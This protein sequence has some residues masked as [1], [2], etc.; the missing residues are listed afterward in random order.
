MKQR[1][2]NILPMI[3]FIMIIVLVLGGFAVYG[4]KN[5][6]SWDS[7]FSGINKNNSHV[8]DDAGELPTNHVGKIIIQ[9]SSPDVYISNHDSE[10]VKANFYGE[11]IG[12]DESERPK[13][14]LYRQG[15]TITVRIVYPAIAGLTYKNA[16]LDVVIPEKWEGDLEINSVSGDIFA[17]EL[18]G[19]DISIN[20][21]SGRIKADV[22]K[23][24]G[25]F[26]NTSVSGDCSIETV[27]CKEGRFNSS[28]GDITIQS[29]KAE[30]MT[31]KTVSGRTKISMT[32]GKAEFESSS[33]KMDIE[34][35]N[36]FD[37]LMAKS[38]SGAIELGIPEDSTFDIN[39][40]TVSGDIDCRD[41]PLKI[42]TS[43]EN[44]LNG[45][46]GDGGSSIDVTTSSGSVKVYSR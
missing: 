6:D 40:K 21:S 27:G 5:K 9:S 36:G 28:S 17:K 3:G 29:A 45:T 37:R 13:L 7:I 11:I 44:E 14:E 4:Q 10:L 22:I 35:V 42:R 20:V 46:A 8:I 16:K 19:D 34:F 18:V 15:E 33:G 30:N 23:A 43:K 38:V 1:G 26:Q 2:T 41:F 24:T 31:I 32:D 12:V 39:V 25:V